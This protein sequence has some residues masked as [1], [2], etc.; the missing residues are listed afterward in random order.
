[1]AS[2]ARLKRSISLLIASSIGVLILPFSL[3]QFAL[4]VFAAATIAD[5]GSGHE[6]SGFRHDVRTVPMIGTLDREG[7]V[8]VLSRSVQGWRF[9]RVRR[10]YAASLAISLSVSDEA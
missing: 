10:R 7:V 5:L 9:V 4:S 1:M 8:R 2:I 6:H 3:S